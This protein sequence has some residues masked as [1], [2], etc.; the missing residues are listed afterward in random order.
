MAVVV[1][2]EDVGMVRSWEGGAKAEQ[3]VLVRA[4]AAAAAAA[5]VR[6]IAVMIVVFIMMERELLGKKYHH[7]VWVWDLGVRKYIHM[8]ISNSNFVL[9]ST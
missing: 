5:V 1:W 3:V 2:R 9:S 8:C 4:R 7:L 6:W